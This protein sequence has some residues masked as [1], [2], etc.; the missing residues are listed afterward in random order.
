[1]SKQLLEQLDFE[2]NQLNENLQN[3]QVQKI[4]Q[5]AQTI[6]ST[7]RSKPWDRFDKRWNDLIFNIDNK[8][9][10]IEDTSDHFFKVV[11]LKDDQGNPITDKVY[12]LWDETSN[13]ATLVTKDEASSYYKRNN[14]KLHWIKNLRDRKAIKDL[15]GKISKSLEQDELTKNYSYKEIILDETSNKA[16]NTKKEIKQGLAVN[17]NSALEYYFNTFCGNNAWDS[18]TGYWRKSM[19]DD[20]RFSKSVTTSNI[21]QFIIEGIVTKVKIRDREF[22]EV[23]NGFT[24]GENE[25]IRLILTPDNSMGISF[26]Y[27][28][29]FD[30]LEKGT[31]FLLKVLFSGCYAKMDYKTILSSFDSYRNMLDHFKDDLKSKI[32]ENLYDKLIEDNKTEDNNILAEALAENIII[33]EGDSIS[34][35][36]ILSFIDNQANKAITLIESDK[37]YFIGNYKATTKAE[38]QAVIDRFNISSEVEQ[39][40]LIISKNN[41]YTLNQNGSKL[42]VNE[43][44]INFKKG[45]VK[46]ARCVES[47][48]GRAYNMVRADDLEKI[49]HLS[50]DLK[51]KVDL[52]Q[53]F[54]IDS[55][56]ELQV[57]KEFSIDN[58]SANLE[59]NLNAQNTL[60]TSITIKGGIGEIQPEANEDEEEEEQEKQEEKKPKAS[61]V[62]SKDDAIQAI[63]NYL[64]EHKTK[65]LDTDAK[66]NT[67]MSEVQDKRYENCKLKAIKELQ[68]QPQLYHYDFDTKKILG[69]DGKGDVIGTDLDTLLLILNK[70]F[71]KAAEEIKAEKVGK[72]N[73][74]GD[75]R[76]VINTK[77]LKA[78]NI[79]AKD[80][81]SKINAIANILSQDTTN[82]TL[83]ANRDV[84]NKI[85]KGELAELIAWFNDR[86]KSS[87]QNSPSKEY[88]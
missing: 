43:N 8:S 20:A 66:V 80:V 6:D 46:V 32:S 62:L 42:L 81:S 1:M 9:A 40:W 12:V 55:N 27:K 28:N 88:K 76:I 34:D 73:I 53:Y 11:D 61:K 21:I 29:L 39:Y 74:T 17:F 51:N 41:Y 79:S 57:I 10:Q 85:S 31:N 48:I 70:Q 18:I 59:F 47:A 56:D 44:L 22:I 19:V 54:K 58:A 3:E 13:K 86:F 7:F 68:E 45:I 69:D 63:T 78:P 84:M 77:K 14:G 37:K 23:L 5:V 83:N 60:I 4:I 67:F 30:T 15:I 50:D 82:D 25:A 36:P 64:K 2:L 71:E 33:Y 65:M 24:G 35:N 72:S 38:R 52:E 87:K 16:L 26:S 49:I 75:D